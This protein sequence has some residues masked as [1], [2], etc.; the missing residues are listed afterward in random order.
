MYSGTH[1]DGE[2]K[3][4]STRRKKKKN[5]GYGSP[6]K[7]T[8]LC[9]GLYHTSIIIS[10]KCVHNLLRNHAN[11]PTHASITSLAEVITRR[12]KT[13]PAATRDST[14]TT[15]SKAMGLSQWCHDV[16]E[17]HHDPGLFLRLYSNHQGH[18]EIPCFFPHNAN[19]GQ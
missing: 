18:H 6:P 16:L 4:D 12:G 3:L 19:R 9:L 7:P 15:A 11:Q 14:A 10:S 13:T 2:N 1:I 17:R 5:P 8:G